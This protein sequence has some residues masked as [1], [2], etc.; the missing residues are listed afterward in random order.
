MRAHLGFSSGQDQAALRTR[1]THDGM[2]F[3][4]TREMQLQD[5]KS[6]VPPTVTVRVIPVSSI[7]GPGDY[8]EITA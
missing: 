1:V 2:T 4:Y 8:S 3:I 6:G 7:T 5:F